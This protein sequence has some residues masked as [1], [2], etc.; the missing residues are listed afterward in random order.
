MDED[1]DTRGDEE[2]TPGVPAVENVVFVLIGVV[3][4]L[5]VIAHL[6]LVFT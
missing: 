1:S 3:S 2:L 6:V 5:A 4:T